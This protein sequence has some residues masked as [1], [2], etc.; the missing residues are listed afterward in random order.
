MLGSFGLVID[1][2]PISGQGA[3]ERALQTRGGSSPQLSHLQEAAVS[4]EG[5]TCGRGR[6]CSQV[7]RNLRSTSQGD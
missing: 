3:V 2:S 1:G 5:G 6:G 4:T 7:V